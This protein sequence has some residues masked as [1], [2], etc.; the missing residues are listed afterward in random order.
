MRTAPRT[1]S[2]MAEYREARAAW[3]N[4]P[5]KGTQAWGHDQADAIWQQT[6]APWDPVVEDQVVLDLGCHWGFLLK[7]LLDEGRRPRRLIGV[8]IRTWWDD[9][10]HGWDWQG[11]GLVELHAGE[12]PDVDLEERSIDL[13][14]CT[15]VFQSILP[16]RLDETLR[17]IYRLLKPGGQ[18]LVR[19]HL[20]TSYLGAGLHRQYD[21]PYVHMLYPERQLMERLGREGRENAPTRP[22]MSWMTS[23]SYLAAYARAGFE[24]LDAPRSTSGPAPEIREQ[25]AEAWPVNH[26]ELFG[27]SLATRLLRPF[28]P[29]DLDEIERPRAG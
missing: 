28:E 27:G 17:A 8:D 29:G 4:E 10:D 18:L 3:V 21:L 1:G 6:Y 19:T 12:L 2:G 11:T 13:M 5:T 23:S 26:D 25:V 24:I 9:F 16:E 7:Y 22:F 15:S 20:Y 14:L